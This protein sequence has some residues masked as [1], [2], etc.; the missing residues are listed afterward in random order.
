ML[1][2]G[3]PIDAGRV[4]LTPRVTL[5]RIPLLA[6]PLPPCFNA[7]EAGVPASP[8]ETVPSNLIRLIPA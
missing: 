8:V 3:E 7:P 5:G 6:L 1:D 2:F 4:H